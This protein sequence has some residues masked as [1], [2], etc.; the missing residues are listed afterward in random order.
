MIIWDFQKVFASIFA[1]LASCGDHLQDQW[2][3]V[4]L[5]DL[6]EANTRITDPVQATRFSHKICLSISLSHTMQYL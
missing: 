6:G 1:I 3:V 5:T 4:I 2:T